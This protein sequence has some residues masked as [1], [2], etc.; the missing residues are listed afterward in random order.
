[1]FERPQRDFLAYSEDVFHLKCLYARRAFMRDIR[2]RESQVGFSPEQL[3]SEPRNI[4]I[5][6]T[7]ATWNDGGGRHF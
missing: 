2:N 3:P 4:A 5:L 6:C 1:M 7:M